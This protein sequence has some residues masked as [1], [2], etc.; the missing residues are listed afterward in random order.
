MTVYLNLDQDLTYPFPA[1]DTIGKQLIPL[2]N[3]ND[4]LDIN[5]DKF[6]VDYGFIQSANTNRKG[7]L[8]SFIVLCVVCLILGVVGTIVVCMKKN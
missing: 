3:I 5:T 7:I 2:Y 6:N 8:I 4:S 1:L